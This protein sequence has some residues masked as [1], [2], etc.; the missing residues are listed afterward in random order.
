MNMNF[1]DT[2]TERF[3]GDYSVLRNINRI[4]C[5]V[6]IGNDRIGKRDVASVAHYLISYRC[7]LADL[8]TALCGICFEGDSVRSV[9]DDVSEIHRIC[10]CTLLYL[11][12]KD[13]FSCFGD[14]DVNFKVS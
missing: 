1:D 8:H 13:V 14:F 2:F 9:K 12:C 11:E 6:C 3:T 4:R 5:F 7:L 10:P